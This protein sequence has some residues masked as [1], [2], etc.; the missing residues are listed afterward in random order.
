RPRPARRRA[1]R[2]AGPSPPGRPPSPGGAWPIGSRAWRRGRP[3]PELHRRWHDMPHEF[4]SGVFTEG[5]P[6][7]HT[8]GVTLPNDGLDTTEALTYSGLAGW[9]LTKQPIYIGNPDDGYTQ[10]P[11]NF[12]VTRSTDGRPLGVVGFGY[13][14]YLQSRVI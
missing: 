7:W 1:A 12:A 2:A 14:I 9:R 10:V 3:A 4:E 6:A 11:D 5:R 13:R 8:L